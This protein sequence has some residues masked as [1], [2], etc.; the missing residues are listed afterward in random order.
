MATPPGVFVQL[1]ASR[2]PMM[3]VPTTSTVQNVL[4]GFMGYQCLPSEGICVPV[5]ATT[6][7]DSNFPLYNT[8]EQCQLQ[9]GSGFGGATYGGFG[10]YTNF[11]TG[12]LD[13][14]TGPKKAPK[15]FD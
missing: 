8:V 7:Y 4:G 1:E 3:L 6:T 14:D 15:I 5:G 11:G 2:S 13:V 10:S 12:D 9:C